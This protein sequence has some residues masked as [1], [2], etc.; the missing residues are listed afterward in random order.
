MVATETA[1]GWGLLIAVAYLLGEYTDV[2]ARVAKVGI[3]GGKG[4]KKAGGNGRAISLAALL[5]GIW[6]GPMIWSFVS[7][8]TAGVFGF[9]AVAGVTGSLDL[10]NAEIVI[11]AAV[12]L[13]AVVTFTD[14]AE[15]A[16]EG[17]D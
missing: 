9:G 3:Y 4:V 17:D 12:S 11:A 1:V 15:D 5:G 14:S 10:T 6:V 2:F 13:L 7:G 16:A 8:I